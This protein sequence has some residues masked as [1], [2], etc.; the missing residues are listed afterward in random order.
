MIK[1]L[2]ILQTES[3]KDQ[4]WSLYKMQ[5]NGIQQWIIEELGLLAEGL[6]EAVKWIKG[7]QF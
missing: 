4:F 3:I 1:T 7:L 5:K 6:A 2:L